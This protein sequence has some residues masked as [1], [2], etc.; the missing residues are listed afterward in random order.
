MNPFNTTFVPTCHLALNYFVPTCAH[1]SCA[2]VPTTTHKIYRGSR[3]YL[4]LLFFARFF[5]LSFHSKPPQKNLASK[6]VYPNPILE[7]FVIST[8]I[9]PE[10]IT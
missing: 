4:A 3:L 8:G 5:D 1:F 6:T 7:G 10:T 9:C 2:Y